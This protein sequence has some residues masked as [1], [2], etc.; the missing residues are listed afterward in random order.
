[1][2]NVLTSFGNIL[3][4][5]PVASGKT[6]W[7]A[8]SAS[9]TINGRT[10]A[11]SDGN[12][13][14]SPYRALRTINRAWALVA[15]SVGDVI[16]LLP[17]THTPQNSA[18]TATSVAASVAGV[19][20]TGLPF[21]G[22]GRSN[23]RMPLQGFKRR[24]IISATLLDELI[25]ITAADVELSY[26]HFTVTQ[27]ADP[28]QQAVDISSAGHRA[29]I[30]DCTFSLVIAADD[31]AAMG[32]ELLGTSDHVAIDHCGFYI[33]NNSGPAIRITGV[34][35]NTMVEASTFEWGRSATALDD[36]VEIA[37]AAL[38][39]TFR[40]LDFIS[41]NTSNVTDCL[42][43]AGATGDEAT[44]IARC[45]FPVG[46]DPVEPAADADWSMVGNLLAQVSGGTGGTAVVS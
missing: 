44:L 37:G 32:I 23:S 42:D 30:H 4:S 28:S 15:A 12:D 14:L 16:V 35:T 45:V 13:G 3:G 21:M 7:V 33:E 41:N 1:M 36:F 5:L 26:L 43:I 24:T 19:T 31:T 40:D 39:N 46:S 8:A 20:M 25:N 9:Y 6:Y 11:A 34:A 22:S 18:G 29:H 10:A 2:S 38:G 27:G 17:G